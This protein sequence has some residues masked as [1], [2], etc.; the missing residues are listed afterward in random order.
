MSVSVRMVNILPRGSP[1]HHSPRNS[2]ALFA[3]RARLINCTLR[4]AMVSVA[5][6]QWHSN[7]TAVAASCALLIHHAH[8]LCIVGHHEL[9]GLHC[10]VGGLFL[11]GSPMW[12]LHGAHEATR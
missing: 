6:Q 3:A 12:R 5:V 4:R 7:G 8:C 9:T 2:F 11:V 10:G 1:C